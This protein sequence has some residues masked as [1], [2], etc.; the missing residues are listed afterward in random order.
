[1]L[2]TIEF[3]VMQ[4]DVLTFNADVVAL[5]YAQSFYGADLEL[6]SNLVHAGMPSFKLEPEV[7]EYRRI[8]TLGHAQAKHALFVGVPN[9]A[10]FGYSEIRQFAADVLRGMDNFAR[11][12][13]DVCMTIHGVGVWPRRNRGLSRTTRGMLGCYPVRSK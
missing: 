1:M 5:K 7:G 2:P 4:G 13:T 11:E 8:D 12:A 6:A 10:R 3:V 9:L